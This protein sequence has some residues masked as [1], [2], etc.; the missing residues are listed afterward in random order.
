MRDVK[1]LLSL[2][3]QARIKLVIGALAVA[4]HPVIICSPWS[5]S[6]P[7]L[8][9]GLCVPTTLTCD[10]RDVK[11]PFHLDASTPSL[12]RSPVA[13]VRLRPG[14]S[15]A[16]FVTSTRSL[17]LSRVLVVA[18]RRRPSPS[19]HR[20]MASQLDPVHKTITRISTSNQSDHREISTLK[21]RFL[22]VY[23]LDRSS[24]TS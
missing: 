23:D 2:A 4:R 10:A 12:P 13:V 24:L 6:F 15:L 11:T 16:R 8:A 14:F 5:A 17:E 20:P 1:T 21:T 7:V 19:C 22:V 18:A 9:L 3:N